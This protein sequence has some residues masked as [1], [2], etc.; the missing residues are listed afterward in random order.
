M[1]GAPGC[2]SVETPFVL[3]ERQTSGC[4]ILHGVK[5]GMYGA[6]CEFRSSHPCFARM[7]H[8][9]PDCGL[10]TYSFIPPF[11]VRLRRMGHPGRVHSHPCFARMGHPGICVVAKRKGP[12]KPLGGSPAQATAEGL[13]HCESNRRLLRGRSGGRCD[14]DVRL[15]GGCG[16]GWVRA[17]AGASGHSC[18]DGCEGTDK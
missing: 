9:A 7:G 14:D 17:V 1:Y 2:A 15:S 16:G 12:A 5:G 18:A 3:R 4:P 6:R 8:P 10:G 11:A 13:L